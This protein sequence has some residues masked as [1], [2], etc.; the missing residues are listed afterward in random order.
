MFKARAEFR[1]DLEVGA[2]ADV[3][4]EFFGDLGNFVRLM[5]GVESIGEEAGGVVC[6]TV[7]VDVGLAGKMRGHFRIVRT[8]N[9]PQRIEWGPAVYEKKNLLR[10][11]ASFEEL[12]PSRTMV[13]VAQRVEL[14]RQSAT[15]LHL[16]AGL[17]GERRI[18]A[19]MQERVASMMKTF[20]KR[21]RAHLEA[22][23]AG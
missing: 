22:L 14:R 4:R 8:D 19:G 15:E 2:S 9:S 12:A 20:L 7:C 18:S 16:M 1:E 10:Y 13:R 21:A 11:A 3:V 17:I 23:N 5:P 6:W